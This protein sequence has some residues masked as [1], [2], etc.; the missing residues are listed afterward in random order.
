MIRA[1][2][3]LVCVTLNVRLVK[4]NSC[5]SNPEVF[6]NLPTS[7]HWVLDQALQNQLSERLKPKKALKCKKLHFKIPL[8]QCHWI[9]K[10]FLNP[11]SAVVWTQS[12]E[13]LWFQN[14]L[15]VK[16]N[17]KFYDFFFLSCVFFF[18]KVK[19]IFKVKAKFS[20]DCSIKNSHLIALLKDLKERVKLSDSVDCK[21][22]VG[23]RNTLILLT[24]M[25]VLK[26]DVWKF[27]V[28]VCGKHRLS[29]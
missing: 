26:I 15:Y 4:S 27:Q 1:F 24:A 19:Y 22:V 21:T 3:L 23:F 29:V 17:I 14:K 2:L 7:F 16:S 18:F 11:L 8:R 20:S 28:L 12:L 13:G 25:A 10:S 9:R 5:K 6:W